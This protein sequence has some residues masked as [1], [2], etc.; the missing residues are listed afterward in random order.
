MKQRKREK[1]NNNVIKQLKQLILL[2]YSYLS[3]IYIYIV[4]NLN[5]YHIDIYTHGMLKF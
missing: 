4:T 1:K 5:I 3:K 2:S